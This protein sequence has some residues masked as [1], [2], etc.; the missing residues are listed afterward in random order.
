MAPLDSFQIVNSEKHTQQKLDSRERI[1]AAVGFVA[2][3]I[4]ARKKQKSVIIIIV[5]MFGYMQGHQWCTCQI[6]LKNYV[7]C[8]FIIITWILKIYQNNISSES[9]P[10]D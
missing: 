3:K 2:P 5:W 7:N 8:R 6:V 9:W 4:L 10:S 1:I